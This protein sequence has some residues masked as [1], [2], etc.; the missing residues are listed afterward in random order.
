LFSFFV[1]H[2]ILTVLYQSGC[3][4]LAGQA[5]VVAS[6]SYNTE[7]D[8][9]AVKQVL[10]QPNVSMSPGKHYSFT[11]GQMAWHLISGE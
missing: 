9:G 6:Y 7:T 10:E 8:L 1:F 11:V 4:R 5:L 2:Q 3:A